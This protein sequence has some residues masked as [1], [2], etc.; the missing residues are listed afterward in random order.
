MTPSKKRQFPVCVCVCAASASPLETPGFSK[1]ATEM[2]PCPLSLASCVETAQQRHAWKRVCGVRVK[3]RRSYSCHKRRIKGS[4]RWMYL[5]D[6]HDAL[7]PPVH[8][9]NQ[10]PCRVAAAFI[11]RLHRQQCVRSLTLRGDVPPLSNARLTKVCKTTRI[12]KAGQDGWVCV[13]QDGPSLAY[14]FSEGKTT[15]R[16][17]LPSCFRAGR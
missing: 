1:A 13:C 7:S 17:W 14:L 5:V 6:G 15:V 10:K 11:D 3:K 12:K 2:V 9:D 4:A 8:I 16:K